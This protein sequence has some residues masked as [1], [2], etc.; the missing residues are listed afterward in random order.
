MLV[1]DQQ[2]LD[3]NNYN[4]SSLPSYIDVIFIKRKNVIK[5]IEDKKLGFIIRFFSMMNI[6]TN[7]YFRKRIS[8]V[9]FDKAIGVELDEDSKLVLFND[10]S[11]MARLFR[12]AFKDYIVIEDGI[13]NYFGSKN[14]YF[15]I[16]FT[17]EKFRVIGSDNRCKKVLL[18]SP[19][20]APDSIKGKVSKISFIN[21]KNVNEYLFPFYR[22]DAPEV[23]F[24]CIIATQP[25]SGLK[26]SKSLAIYSA[27]IDELIV[28]NQRFA[29]KVHPREIENYYKISLPNEIFIDS[30]VPLELM[31]FNSK[32]KVKIISI[33]STAGLGF[34]D[35]CSRVTLI[36][37]KDAKYMLNIINKWPDDL[38][39]I[40]KNILQ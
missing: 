20:K 1:I 39:L 31:I 5:E 9:I 3:I 6:N 30:K 28:T 17:L 32:I 33:Y 4:V 11:K 16:L 27:V 7:R 37:E 12:L 8:K 40:T 15:Q 10:R 23:E 35:Y 36:D 22:V 14:N 34:E 24:D 19:E 13:A 18:L 29:I 25:V 2:N 26:S 21:T 38:G